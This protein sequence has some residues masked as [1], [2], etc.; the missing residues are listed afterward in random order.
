M[1]AVDGA[2][3]RKQADVEHR[4]AQPYNP[5]SKPETNLSHGEVNDDCVTVWFFAPYVNRT[6]SPTD[7]V[8]VG[9]V[10]TSPALPPTKMLCVTSGALDVVSGNMV[11]QSQRDTRQQSRG[12]HRDESLP[13][14][15]TWWCMRSRQR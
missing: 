14:W 12:T 11:S 2:S 13:S 6:T 3:E 1:G 10:Y 7:A 5:E 8:T 15:R 9:G 4:G